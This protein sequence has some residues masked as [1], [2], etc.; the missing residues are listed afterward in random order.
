VLCCNKMDVDDGE[1]KVPIQAALRLSN[2]FGKMGANI[3]DS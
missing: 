2:K 3:T 1:K